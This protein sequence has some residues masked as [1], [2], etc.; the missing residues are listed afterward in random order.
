MN[1]HVQFGFN[2]ICSFEKKA[3][4]HFPI[5]FNVNLCI[6]V[7]AILD[8]RSTYKTYT[9]HFKMP[10][11]RQYDMRMCNYHDYYKKKTHTHNSKNFKLKKF[12]AEQP[13]MSVTGTTIKAL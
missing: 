11:R 5:G 6:A 4:E 9:M 3:F 7:V 10:S 2:N 12:N 8:S 1:I 13:A